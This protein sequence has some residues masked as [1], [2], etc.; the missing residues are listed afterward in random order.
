[1]KRRGEAAGGA[2]REIPVALRAPS[3]SLGTPNPNPR[4]GHFYFG[5]NRTFLNWLDKNKENP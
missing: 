4:I 2:A 3:I 5:K 1:M